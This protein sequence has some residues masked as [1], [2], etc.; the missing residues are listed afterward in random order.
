MTILIQ[1]GGSGTIL[2]ANSAE[3][4]AW[5]Q[6]LGS[7]VAIGVTVVQLVIA[8]REVHLLREAEREAASETLSYAIAELQRFM[9]TFES[10]AFRRAP[11]SRLVELESI[12]PLIERISTAGLNSRQLSAVLDSQR[13]VQIALANMRAAGEDERDG[14]L[15]V[16]YLTEADTLH[17]RLQKNVWSLFPKSVLRKVRVHPAPPTAKAASEG[18][19]QRDS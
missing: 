10:A 11:R 4:A 5:F 18:R 9:L 1:L 6:A 2:P 14:P 12:G 13:A 3:W 17:G 16:K 7:L 15:M 19:V 8:R